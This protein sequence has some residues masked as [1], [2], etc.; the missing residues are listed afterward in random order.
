MFRNL[1]QNTSRIILKYLSFWSVLI[2]LSIF[3]TFSI[4]YQM[5][6]TLWYS[7]N[8]QI[9]LPLFWYIT[10]L[11]IVLLFEDTSK[12]KKIFFTLQI[13]FISWFILQIHAME[14]MYYLMHLSILGIVYFKPIYQFIKKYYYR[15]SLFI[16][17]TILS[18]KTVLRDEFGFVKYLQESHESLL[19]LILSTGETVVNRYNRSNYAINEL[20]YVI[21]TLGTIT[22]L[23]AT[24]RWYKKHNDINY[25]LFL[26]ILL[27]SL[28]IFIP[29]KY[30]PK[31]RLLFVISI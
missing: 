23:W 30:H 20:M 29:H 21:L 28:F 22:F 4:K 11:S 19:G 26:Y 18:I 5:V 1:F 2:W 10:A 24:W 17:V 13:L 15:V 8:Y 27:S 6:W 25:R 12:T 31:N 16:I 9:S 7:V 14:F 3:A